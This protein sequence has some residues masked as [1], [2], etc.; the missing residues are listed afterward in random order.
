MLWKGLNLTE[1]LVDQYCGI[2]SFLNLVGIG[3]LHVNNI[4]ASLIFYENANK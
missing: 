2:P 3:L 1:R 4:T